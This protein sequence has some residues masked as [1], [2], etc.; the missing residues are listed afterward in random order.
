V[1]RNTQPTRLPD[2]APDQ[3]PL[4]NGRRHP[5]GGAVMVSVPAGS[6]DA[7]F[8]INGQCVDGLVLTFRTGRGVL[9]SVTCSPEATRY[10]DLHLT[11]RSQTAAGLGIRAGDRIKLIVE[12]SGRDTDQWRILSV[13]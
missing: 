2:L 12:R 11:V 7:A 10:G 4:L 3:T 9:G 13:S 5:A 8:V 1:L 6:A